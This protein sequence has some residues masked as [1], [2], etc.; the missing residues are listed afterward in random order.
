MDA[1]IFNLFLAAWLA[2]FAPTARL[3]EPAEP[4]FDHEHKQ[5]SSVLA[6]VVRADRVDYAV[7]A[8]DRG[9]L[10][11]YL[12]KLTAQDPAEFAQWSRAERLA[13]WINAY[14]AFTVHAVLANYPLENVDSL[15]DVG[16]KASGKVW[17]QR[18]LRLGR[19]VPGRA[20]AE[21]SLDELR[22][23]VLRFEF[24]DARVHAALCTSCLG[25]PA[26][27]S[28]AFTATELDKQL[29]A[30]ARAWLG[31]PLRAKFAKER[32]LVEAPAV[33]E[34]FKPDFARDAG[35]VEAWIARYAPLSERAWLASTADW[36]LETLPFDWKLND[37]EHEAK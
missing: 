14:N 21:L 15:R 2:L 13:F 9:V 22:D 7:L 10:D 8:R 6:S 1:R 17:K 25:S 31:D 4:G 34:D 30:A 23:D 20:E 19:L 12:S 28:T 11:Q 3:Q 16:G 5:W 18:N 37:V 33:L 35:S 36:R 27:R 29:D 32:K 24:K 26:L